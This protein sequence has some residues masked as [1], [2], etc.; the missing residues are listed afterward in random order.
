MKTPTWIK[1]W[2]TYL[3]IFHLLLLVTQSNVL[4]CVVVHCQ[5]TSAVSLRHCAKFELQQKNRLRVQRKS[6]FLCSFNVEITILKILPCIPRNNKLYL[7]LHCLMFWEGYFI[8]TSMKQFAINIWVKNVSSN[9]HIHFE[10]NIE[11]K[12]SKV[13]T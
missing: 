13:Q 2:N 6:E 5:S 8:P 10:R 9:N 11:I 4:L 1:A 7:T 3:P 12:I